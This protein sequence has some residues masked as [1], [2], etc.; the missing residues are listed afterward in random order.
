MLKEPNL[1]LGYW[2]E[3]MKNTINIKMNYID[4]LL[5]VTKL[6]ELFQREQFIIKIVLFN[7]LW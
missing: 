6:K 5:K 3:R 7:F 4:K 1:K 2:Y